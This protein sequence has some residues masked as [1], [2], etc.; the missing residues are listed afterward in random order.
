[1]RAIRS[2][3]DTYGLPHGVPVTYRLAMLPAV[4]IGGV[5]LI[6]LLLPHTTATTLLMVAFVLVA[7]FGGV[8]RI[9]TARELS[10]RPPDTR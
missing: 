3:L 4:I 10:R 6:Y 9:M 8:W 7:L 5:A 1:M 2:F